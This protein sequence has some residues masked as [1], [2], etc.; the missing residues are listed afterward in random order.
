MSYNKKL[1]LLR[2]SL[3][4]LIQYAYRTSYNLHVIDLRVF[5]TSVG[6]HFS[7]TDLD[8][9]EDICYRILPSCLAESGVA[10]LCQGMGSSRKRVSTK[11]YFTKCS[12]LSQRRGGGSPFVKKF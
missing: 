5:F 11:S 6:V 10:L 8:R 2:L 9:P 3:W 12:V 7:T 4:E 1:F